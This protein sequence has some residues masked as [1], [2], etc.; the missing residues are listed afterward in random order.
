[1]ERL[2][3]QQNAYKGHFTRCANSLKEALESE[4]VDSSAVMKYKKSLHDK[5]QIIK[6]HSDTIQESIEDDDE[7]LREID[8]VEKIYETYVELFTKAEFVLEEKVNKSRLTNST[9]IESKHR[10]NLPV[11]SLKKFSGEYEEYQ[12]FI[13]NFNA[14]V[15]NSEDLEP[16]EKFTYLK[17]HLEGDAAALVKGYSTTNANYLEALK[18]LKDNF[19][20]KDLIIS[21]HISN[22]LKLPPCSDHKD[23]KSLRDLL[24]AIHTRLRSLT[25]LGIT[26][27]DHSI[28][29]VPIILSKLPISISVMWSRK[30]NEPDID[31]LL[32]MVQTEVEGY[33]AAMRV[34]EVF[35][36]ENRSNTHSKR[37][38]P[39][40]RIP[41]ASALHVNTKKYCAICKENSTH[42]TDKCRTFVNSNISERKSYCY[43]EYVCF[44][45]LKKGHMVKNC[46]QRNS[47]KCDVCHSPYHNTLLHE[48]QRRNLQNEDNEHDNTTRVEA[49]I[50]DKNYTVSKA[51]SNYKALF[52][53]AT[54]IL[55]DDEGN[56]VQIRILFD[57]ASDKSY[58]I[59][60]KSSMLNM[61]FHKESLTITGFGDKRGENGLHIIRHGK[62]VNLHDPNIFVD[63]NLVETETITCNL[64]RQPVPVQFLDHRYTKGL[65][66]AE[67][68]SVPNNNDIDV[69]V[70]LDYYWNF[71][72]GRIKRQLNKP[73]IVE[74]ILGWIIQGNVHGDN[75]NINTMLCNSKS[76]DNELN[77]EI[78]SLFELETI[79]I[80]PKEN[81][82]Y[83]RTEKLAIHSFEK[84]AKYSE[85]KKQWSV[86]LPWIEERDMGRNEQTALKRFYKLEQRFRKN[87]EFEVKYREA[88][89]EYISSGYAE[90]VPNNE[91]SL[92]EGVSYQPHH[93]VIKEDRESTKVRLVFDGSCSDEGKESINDKL[94]KGPAL[95]PLLVDILIRFRIHK[96]TLNADIRK[97][98]LNIS[99]NEED[100]NSLRFVWRPKGSKNIIHFRHTVLPF[101]I[102][103]SPFLAI[104]VIRE[105]LKLK[106]PSNGLVVEA[107]TNDMY[108]DDLLTGT[109]SE[110][111]AKELYYDC[112]ASMSSASMNLVKWKSNNKDICRM[113]DESKS[114]EVNVNSNNEEMNVEFN[115]FDQI[116]ENGITQN[117]KIL[118]IHWMTKEDKF[119]YKVENIVEKAYTARIT[120]RNIF[121][122][123]SKLYD[124]LGL[125][126]PYIVKIKL[127]MTKL[128]EA[129]YEWDEEI[130]DEMKKIWQDWINEIH[131]AKE[132]SI[133]RCYHNHNNEVKSRILH[134]FGDA[135]EEAF[136]A[137]AYLVTTDEDSVT[138]SKLVMSKTRVSPIKRVTLPRLELLAAL[139]AVRLGKYIEN[140]IKPYKIDEIYYWTDS[141]ITLSWIQSKSK[142]LKPFVGNRIQEIQDLSDPSQWRKC[143]GEDNPA[144]HPSRGRN[145][146]MLLKCNEW[147]NGPKWL[148]NKENWPSYERETS[149]DELF[150]NEYRTSICLATNS[151]KIVKSCIDP[152]NNSSWRKLIGVTARIKRL[153][154]NVKHKE[155]K[156]LG[157]LTRP[158]LNS[159]R[160]YWIKQIQLESFIEEIQLLKEN[161]LITSSSKLYGLN[162]FYDKTDGYLKLEG[163]IQNSDLP[164]EVKHPIVLPYDHHAVRLLVLEFHCKQ[165][166]AGISHTFITVRNKF[167]IIKGRRLV[168][169]VVKSCMVCKLAKPKK[170]DVLFGQLPSDRVIPQ[171]PFSVVGIDFTGPLYVYQND[172]CKKMYICLFTCST[173][174]AVHLELVYDLSCES[175]I[176]SFRRFISIRG[177]CTTIYTDNAKT[178]KKAHKDLSQCLN[179]FENERFKEMVEEQGI[180]WKFIVPLA[181]WWGG[182]YESLMSS[183]KAPLKKI[184]KGSLLDVDELNTVLYEVSAMINS[185]PLTYVSDD[186][187]DMQYITPSMF[188][189]GRQT[190]YVPLSYEKSTTS[191]SE[192]IRNRRKLQNKHLNSIW[193][194]WRTKYLSQLGFNNSRKSSI[195]LKVGQLVQV[196]DHSIPRQI[197]KIGII[198]EM[199]PGKDG[200]IRSVKVKISNGKFICRHVKHISILE[201]DKD[202]DSSEHE[203]IK[204]IFSEITSSSKNKD[205]SNF[206]DVNIP[207]LYN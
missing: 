199:Y 193:Q 146:T 165:L 128:W 59:K 54:A 160:D 163:R 101:G 55:K 102:R 155:S 57:T 5:F 184:L 95:Q 99:I 156:R 52:Q 127:F 103:S 154:Y 27:K 108:M 188:L 2:R 196:L 92:L 116:I 171:T 26:V 56:H 94:L 33:E 140:A 61:P 183:I 25:A 132:I 190:M 19:G 192:E 120:K 124:P 157:I 197:W 185:R 177:L 89:E 176:K 136:A 114:N 73:V 135:S 206:D 118:G 72:T 201:C 67:D 98:Y 142:D 10:I 126:S 204:G 75:K 174:R 198:N 104:S 121:S 69:L 1:M 186:I 144:D 150:I 105:H 74:S 110:V 143:S 191:T 123:A 152:K 86:S 68:Y 178:F 34:Q 205:V 111:K 53:T 122:L 35:A 28:F 147:W 175:F 7:M 149:K 97:M 109:D 47:H 8:E 138:S 87:P 113:F 12:E 115:K 6:E 179:I 70:G 207:E 182:F 169:E 66:F 153:F 137:A 145:L 18:L 16:V 112:K 43:D 77:K 203:M 173:T 90:K 172:D 80:L 14:S 84:N 65:T 20:R 81:P 133:D 134:V 125:I 3:K 129:G 17:A 32:E 63:V 131:K 60:R 167:W 158:E 41:T 40:Y 166:H 200:I 31:Q 170:M 195:N 107:L 49:T 64:K 79:G 164:V 151:K 91:V 187:N 71:I 159:A 21:S 100:R 82:C 162:P 11:L 83:N 130:S 48:F 180:E 37:K 15:H 39:E 42:E 202:V 161:K 96:I 141:S 117:H 36:D 93:A 22:L 50:S 148:K 13:D 119:T 51:N 76:C 194:S 189:I 38:P 29:V 181:P 46:P 168:K 139:I 78:K 58:V 9:M 30:K 45:C 24:N 4:D 23:A 106:P 62:I 88:M 85:D 44:L